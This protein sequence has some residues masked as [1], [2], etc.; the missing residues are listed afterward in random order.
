[1][2]GDPEDLREPDRGLPEVR[3]VHGEAA[4]QRRQL[5][6]EGRRLVRG[7]LLVDAEE[8][9]VDE[10]QQV[11]GERARREGGDEL[12]ELLELLELLELRLGLLE[13]R[14]G[15]IDQQLVTSR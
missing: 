2:G 10:Q 11:H 5:H 1:M 15:W 8:R 14:L 13:L 3:E 6:L 4:D 12:V 7:P 9:F